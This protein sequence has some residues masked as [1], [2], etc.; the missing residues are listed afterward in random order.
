M[1]YKYI[2]LETLTVS[3]CSF[4]ARDVRLSR[5]PGWE[6]NSWGYHGDDGYSFAAEK[7]GTPFGPTFGS[8]HI[9]HRFVL[10]MLI[11]CSGGYNWLRYRFYYAQGVLHEE[12]DVNW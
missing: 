10:A 4:A 8:E 11:S 1:Q 3:C 2:I 6:S 7:S 12:R 9:P 5:L